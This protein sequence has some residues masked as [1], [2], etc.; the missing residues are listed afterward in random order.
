M[1]HAVRK[2]G[3]R[4]G[5]VTALA[6]SMTLLGG[7]GPAQA[8]GGGAGVVTGGVTITT[9]ATGIPVATAAPVAT[10]YTFTSTVITGNL[11]VTSGTSAATYNGLVAVTASGGS[12]SEN[13]AG[14]TG[15]V[16]I[17]ALAGTDPTGAT[18]ALAAS[19]APTGHF[20]RLG[21][22]VDV[23]LRFSVTITP[24]IGPAITGGTIVTLRSAQF[25]PTSGNGV[26]T[27]V[28]AATFAG[29]YAA[30]QNP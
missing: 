28:T 25:V 18:I 21:T 14:G 10:T 23:E 30:V 5:L 19:P 16:T 29:S 26:T 6:A 4:A 11:T 13:A 7:V 1:V 20:L 15:T 24:P 8:A 17:T 12:A 3:A 9:P 27:P 2:L 22:N